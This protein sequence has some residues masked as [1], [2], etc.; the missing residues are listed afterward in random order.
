MM[1]STLGVQNSVVAFLAAMSNSQDVLFTAIVCL[2]AAVGVFA[3]QTDIS[4]QKLYLQERL[5]DCL[6]YG[7]SYAEGSMY[8]ARLFQEQERVYGNGARNVLFTLTNV[9]SDYLLMGDIDNAQAQ[10]TLVLRR[11][12]ALTGLGLAKIRFAALEGLA[13][14]EQTR[15]EKKWQDTSGTIGESPV[16][17]LLNALRYIQKAL[18]EATTWFEPCSRRTLRA[19]ECQTQ[20]TNLLATVSPKLM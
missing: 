16:I 4:W 18:S 3:E 11:S 1:A 10:Y 2:R 9:A 17:P 5:C 15:F 7:K 8:R 19:L 13:L 12:K 6:Y 20:V 14:C